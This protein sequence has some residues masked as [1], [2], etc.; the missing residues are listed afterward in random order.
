MDFFLFKDL[1]D[2]KLR[3]IKQLIVEL[4]KLKLVSSELRLKLKVFKSSYFLKELLQLK[5]LIVFFI[6]YKMYFFRS[7]YKFV[8]FVVIVDFMKKC[9]F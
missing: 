6:D 3:S 5:K 2:F 4:K 7:K 8:V 1:K 9:Y